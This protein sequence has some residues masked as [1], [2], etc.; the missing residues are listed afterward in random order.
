MA[1][2]WWRGGGERRSAA[3][4]RGP[5]S[6]GAPFRSHRQTETLL[7]VDFA[8][9]NP[10]PGVLPDAMTGPVL[11]VI[12]ARL[13][14]SRLPRKPLHPLL[15][16]P[17]IQW[18]V[19]RAAGMRILD[20]VV[21]A[22][23]A[24]EIA[25]ACAGLGIPV[26]MT[27]PDHPSGTDRVAEVVQGPGYD[28]YGVVVNLQGDEPL[29]EEA[30][31]RAAVEE[32]RR[33]RDVGTCA[34]PVGSRE[35]WENPS[36]VKVVRRSDGTALYFSR[37]PIPHPR[38]GLPG[39]GAFGAAPF[40]RHL[41]LYAYR[42]DALLR[43]VAL[44]PSP[45]EELERLEQLRALEAGMTIGVAVVEGGEPGVDTPD[46]VVLVERRLGELGLG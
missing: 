9:A 3:D 8:A 19:E 24:A 18:V 26:A 39:E 40:L 43:W 13:G 27:D 33:G 46:D 11:G 31:V 7:G 22:T 20:Q 30:H 5:P 1:P 21:V 44:P 4:G 2:P 35:R 14:S 32:V 10:S 25:E 28:G 12:P 34:T 38:D 16:R 41:G 6:S 23:D 36:V 42:R 45:L 37:S 29:M 17:L 15:G